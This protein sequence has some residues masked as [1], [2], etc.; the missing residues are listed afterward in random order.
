MKKALIFF[1]LIISSMAVLASDLV[2]ES[3]TQTF[4]D[5]E[6]KIKLDGGVKVKMD[7]LTIESPKADVSIRRNNKL[8][9]ATFYDK[10]YAFEVNLNK[11]R[12]VKANILQ[13]SLIN[14][15]VRAEGDT[16]SIISEG[17]TPI[18][19]INADEQEYD[20]KSNVMV[21]NG[22]VAIKYKDIES[23]SDKAVIIADTKGGLKKIDLIG[24]ARVKQENNNS[25]GHH[26]IYNPITEEMSVSGNTKTIAITD[27]GKKLTIH[28]DYQQ[29][30][31]KQNSYIGNGHVKIWF[32]DYYAQGPKVS[33]FP[34]LETGKPNKVYFVGRSKIVQ[35]DKD[36]IADKIRLT[37]EPKDFEAEGNVRTII[38]NI[39]TK[40][41]DEEL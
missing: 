6:K 36:I 38:H 12:E 35:E 14:K 25:E 16:Q 11:K 39:D 3:K 22:S 27:D 18:V 13:V 5:K 34:D 29:Y 23:F 21:A 41:V 10:P 2:I 7:N 40:E 31:K 15:V 17:N 32:D 9:T 24:N 4:S 33:V 26:F 8:D 20:T 30:N 28:A 1:L 19:V 37:L